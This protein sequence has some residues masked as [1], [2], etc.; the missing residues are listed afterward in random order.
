MLR[1]PLAGAVRSFKVLGVYYDYSTERGY[2]LLDRKTLLKYLPDHAESNLAV[3]LKP[4]TDVKL[5]AMEST[6]S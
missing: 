1:L 4:G 6:G 5:C 3:Y 2:I